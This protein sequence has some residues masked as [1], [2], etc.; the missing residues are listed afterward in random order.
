MKK[1]IIAFLVFFSFVGMSH[2]DSRSEVKYYNE[3]ARYYITCFAE[4][5]IYITNKPIK[6]VVEFKDGIVRYKQMNDAYGFSPAERCNIKGLS[7]HL[8]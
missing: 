8:D 5:G 2:A 1:Y 3:G 4:N 6:E 7:G